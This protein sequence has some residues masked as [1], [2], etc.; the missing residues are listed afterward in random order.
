MWDAISLKKTS[1][2]TVKQ[3]KIKERKGKTVVIVSKKNIVSYNQNHSKPKERIKCSI[4]D[5]SREQCKLGNAI[6]SIF[7][8]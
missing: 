4:D 8:L 6:V 3:N 5:C 1:L 7:N 2:E